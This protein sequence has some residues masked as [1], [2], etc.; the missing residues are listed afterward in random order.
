MIDLQTEKVISIRDACQ[1]LPR[2]RGGKRPHF[3]TLYRWIQRGVRGVRLESI[4]VG[5]EFCTSVEALQRFCERCTDPT[6]PKSRTSKTR[7]RA[8]DKADRELAAEGI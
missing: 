4:K 7:Q 2:R 8:I 5:G 1:M 6:A 3:A